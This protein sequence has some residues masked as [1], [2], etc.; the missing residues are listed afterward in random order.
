MAALLRTCLQGVLVKENKQTSSSSQTQNNPVGQRKKELG[1]GGMIHIC[2]QLKSFFFTKM[3]RERMLYGTLL[4]YIPQKAFAPFDMFL[5]FLFD[6][7]SL[8]A[9]FI[10]P[11]VSTLSKEEDP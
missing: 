10:L 9:V 6:S 1:K 7:V 3:E 8:S 5:N 4:C 11:C 2:D